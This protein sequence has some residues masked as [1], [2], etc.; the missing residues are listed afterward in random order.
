MTLSLALSIG[1]VGANSGVRHSRVSLAQNPAMPDLQS[2]NEQG[3][4]D[5]DSRRGEGVVDRLWA[6]HIARNA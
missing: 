5:C 4:C 1:S 2:V 3:E 6:E